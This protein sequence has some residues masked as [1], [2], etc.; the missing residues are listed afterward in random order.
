MCVYKSSYIPLSSPHIAF[1]S[2]ALCHYFTNLTREFHVHIQPYKAYT[3][4]YYS[5]IYNEN[6][7]IICAFSRET[8][9]FVHLHACMLKY[10]NG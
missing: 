4:V 5:N 10:L 8:E 6:A 3:D 2:A 9:S 1:T 7:F